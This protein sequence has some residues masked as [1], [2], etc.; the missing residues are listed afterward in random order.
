MSNFD[1]IQSLSTLG[2]VDVMPHLNLL[3]GN[4]GTNEFAK[5]LNAGF[6]KE[7]W[8]RCLNENK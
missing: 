3:R 7:F 5:W 6:D 8:E 2:F 1:F 4:I